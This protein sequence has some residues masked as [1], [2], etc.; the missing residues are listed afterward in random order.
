VAAVRTY[1]EEP[2]TDVH[3]VDWSEDIKVT[4]T[5]AGKLIAIS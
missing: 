1:R 5:I 3:L 4:S 2:F